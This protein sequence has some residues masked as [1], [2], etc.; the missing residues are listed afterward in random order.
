MHR[1]VPL[2]RVDEVGLPVVVLEERHVAA[3]AA[4][5]THA[6]EVAIGA[7]GAVGH[8][9]AGARL[10]V[11][12]AVDVQPHH[13]LLRPRVVDDL[14]PLDDPGRVKVV[15]RIVC[16]RGENDALV[17][18]AEEVLRRVAGD[19][20]RVDAP[21]ERLLA[22]RVRRVLVL[23]EPV[24]RAAVEED[25]A[26]VSLDGPAVHVE[27]DGARLEGGCCGLGRGGRRDQQGQQEQKR[28]HP[29]KT[30]PP[31]PRR[32]WPARHS[33]PALAP[34]IALPRA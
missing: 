27:P 15:L 19:A 26:A 1:G 24:V 3:L 4:V 28:R 10:L 32:E 7:G 9:H 20:D 16:H 17:L 21:E 23:A 25:A 5:G 8:R 34:P 14:R 13:V 33:T 6:A 29:E 12:G 31:P 11:V 18:P 30:H 2:R 22:D